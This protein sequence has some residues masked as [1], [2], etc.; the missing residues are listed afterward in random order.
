MFVLG[1]HFGFYVNNFTKFTPA[2]V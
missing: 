2:Y 1:L